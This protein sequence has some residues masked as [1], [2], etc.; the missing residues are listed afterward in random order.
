M[1][2]R[3]LLAFLLLLSTSWAAPDPTAIDLRA[4]L[5]PPAPA[6]K[7]TGRA[8]DLMSS[9]KER[10]LPSPPLEER[11]GESGPFVWPVPGPERVDPYTSDSEKSAPDPNIIT[12]QWLQKEMQEKHDKFL[13][14]VSIP[15]A[16]K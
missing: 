12:R 13:V 1:R 5:P 15:D 6:K 8:V 11:A 3:A 9:Q 4:P 2:S 14:R 16:V 10:S 7:Q